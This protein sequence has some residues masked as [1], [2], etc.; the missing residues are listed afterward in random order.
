[1]CLGLKLYRHIIQELQKENAKET[2]HSKV[3]ESENKLL[4]TEIAQ[5]REV[6]KISQVMENWC[7]KLLQDMRKLE[8]TFEQTLVRE[9]KEIAGDA[10]RSGS[11]EDATSLQKTNRELKTKY[12]VSVTRS[13][14]LHEDT[15]TWQAEIEQLRRNMSE[16]E[17]KSARAVHD[18]GSPLSLWYLS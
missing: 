9:E 8:D 12:E 15:D 16:A 6:W 18:V 4:V 14:L 2:Q 11:L 5:L 3:L 1:M 7:N 17:R 10:A 13:T